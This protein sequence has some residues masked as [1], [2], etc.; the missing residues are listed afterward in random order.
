VFIETVT[1][2]VAGASNTVVF[3]PGAT[4]PTTET[5]DL[6]TIAP[7]ILGC[8][9][10]ETSCNPLQVNTPGQTQGY[11]P[12]RAGTRLR[13]AYEQGFDL[14]SAFDVV[15]TPTTTNANLTARQRAE[16]RVVPNPYIVQDAYDVLNASSSVNQS[17]VMFTNL[18]SRGTL[19][20]YSVSGQFLQELRWTASDL[21][22]TGDLPYNLRTREGTELASGLYIYVVKAK[23]ADGKEQTA[24]GKFVVIR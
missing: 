20:V 23:D 11:L 1:R 7:A 6:V 22:G 5:V 8:A 21:N 15:V 14:T 4:T 10:G 17:R 19:R 3:E 16:I 9:T 18:P 13:F 12:Y 2:P 24:R